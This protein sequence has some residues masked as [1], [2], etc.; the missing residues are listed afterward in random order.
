ML[1]DTSGSLLLTAGLLVSITDVR[2]RYRVGA[3][4][5]ES[6]AFWIEKDTPAVAQPVPASSAFVAASGPACI[7]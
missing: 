4:I 2:R 5:L 1:G 7:G 3:R 6:D